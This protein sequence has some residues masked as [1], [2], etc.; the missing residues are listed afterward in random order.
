MIMDNDILRAWLLIHE[1]SDQLAHN[2]KISNTIHSQATSIKD[3]AVHASSGFALRR[4][5]TDISKE[6]FDS[7]LERMNAQFIIENQTLLHENKQFSI[8]LKEYEST[9]ETIMSK[10]R[11]HALAA[12]QHELTLTRHY[13]GLLLACDSQ[14]QYTDLTSET[15]TAVGLQRLA[16][17]LRALHRSMSGEEPELNDDGTPDSPIDITA[18]LQTLDQQAESE[19]RDDWALERE[20]EISRLEKE[21]EELRKM[22]GIDSAS[23]SEKGIT[24]DL[25]REES[26]RISTSLSVASRMRSGSSSSG[27]RMS[28]WAFEI[29]V[30]QERDSNP[31]NGWESQ[32]QQQPQQQPLPPPPQPQRP[33]TQQRIQPQH[34]P[35][36]GGGLRMQDPIYSNQLPYAKTMRRPANLFS[37]NPGPAPPVSVGSSVGWAQST[38]SKLDRWTSPNMADF[39]H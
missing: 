4:F 33:Q 14:N 36:L 8:L 20:I 24:L 25:E 3:Q 28:P 34:P 23:L 37:P 16:H 18:L 19:I 17:T 6:I 13:E 32:P 31:W 30:P 26:S 12:Q 35:Q 9:M 22:L 29:D 11:N 39:N 21:N 10:F 15:K 1:L 5:N 27:S 38:P 2:Q 7:E